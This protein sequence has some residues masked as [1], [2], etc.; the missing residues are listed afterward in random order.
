M[1][2]NGFRDQFQVERIRERLWS[3]REYGRAAVMVGAGFS[4]NAERGSPDLPIFPLWGE[5]AEAM[6]D[7]LYLAG[8]MGEATREDEKKRRTA[9]AGAMRLASEYETVFGRTALDDFL[10][11]QPVEKPLYASSGSH[12]RAQ[13]PRYCSVLALICK[14]LDAVLDHP[15]VL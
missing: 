13:K 15:P 4:R 8:L 9:G 5:I 11:Q 12:S 3:G 2:G 1:E 10:T 14:C 6:Y 7:D